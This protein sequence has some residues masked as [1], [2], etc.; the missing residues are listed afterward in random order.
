VAVDV[1]KKNGLSLTAIAEPSCSSI[2]FAASLL[3]I[4]LALLFGEMLK[5]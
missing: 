2:Y 5:R 4:G 3:V 1:N